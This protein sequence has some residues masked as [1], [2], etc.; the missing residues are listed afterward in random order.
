MLYPGLGLE[1]EEGTCL[2]FTKQR[3]LMTNSFKLHF[4]K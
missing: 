4:K 2:N 3:F 1:E